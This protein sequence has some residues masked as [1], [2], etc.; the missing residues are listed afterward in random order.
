MTEKK[1]QTKPQIVELSGGNVNTGIERMIKQLIKEREERV[2]K[3]KPN[4]L[5]FKYKK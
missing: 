4:L 1:K 2:T 5:D 3:G